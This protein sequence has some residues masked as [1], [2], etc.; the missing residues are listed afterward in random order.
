MGYTILNFPGRW[1]CYPAAV[2]AA[3]TYARQRK[4][5]ILVIYHGPRRNKMDPRR[6]SFW[7][8]ANGKVQHHLGPK[9]KYAHP[10]EAKPHI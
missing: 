3:R 4:V 9:G 2:N 5:P 6:V 10:P 8:L 1:S 7:I